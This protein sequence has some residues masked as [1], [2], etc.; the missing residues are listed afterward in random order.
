MSDTNK[1]PPTSS[2]TPGGIG[3]AIRVLRA[4]R[5][6]S[7]GEL[8]NLAHISRSTLSDLET[9]RNH[10]PIAAT[11]SRIAL[12]LGVTHQ[13]L[14]AK[15]DHY[16]QWSHEDSAFSRPSGSLRSAAARPYGHSS[17]DGLIAQLEST[18]PDLYHLL[19]D[20]ARLS[21]ANRQRITDQLKIWLYDLH[22]DRSV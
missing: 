3:L 16:A 12:A 21:D 11:V 22:R 19:E 20:I 5:N 15:A 8:C 1:V 18:D 7:A 17:E 14:Q 9:G 2:P 6:M 10:N 13:Q 4:E